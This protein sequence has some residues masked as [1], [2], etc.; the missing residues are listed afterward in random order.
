MIAIMGY[1]HLDASDANEF[2]ADIQVLAT[3][4]RAEKGCL[5]YTVALDDAG[6]GRMLVA[7]RWQD[8]KSLSAHLEAP[9]TVAFVKKWMN[10]FEG[11]LLKYDAANERSLMD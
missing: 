7:E 10:R 2:L 1:V 4:T 6:A 3:T 5:F 8:Q 9:K 11:E